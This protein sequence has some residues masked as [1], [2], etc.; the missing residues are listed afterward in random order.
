MHLATSIHSRSIARAQIFPAPFSLR[1][2]YSRTL[3]FFFFSSWS[4]RSHAARII[5]SIFS[6]IMVENKRDVPEPPR[7]TPRRTWPL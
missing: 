6:H 7:K 4:P 1:P 2:L 5:V 3:M